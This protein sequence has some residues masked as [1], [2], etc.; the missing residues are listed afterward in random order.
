MYK[1]IKIDIGMKLPVLQDKEYVVK[2][3]QS[4]SLEPYKLFEALN[5]VRVFAPQRRKVFTIKLALLGKMEKPNSWAEWLKS[6]KED[7]VLDE[8]SKERSRKLFGERMPLMPKIISQDSEV[9]RG[10]GAENSD[11]NAINPNG[12]CSDLLSLTMTPIRSEKNA[13]IERGSCLSIP[14]NR[15]QDSREGNPGCRPHGI[16]A[17]RV[18]L[19]IG[20]NF[21]DA[22]GS[23]LRIEKVR[24][25]KPL[26]GNN[27]A[28]VKV[29][30]A[31][32]LQTKPR[33]KKRK[34]NPILDVEKHNGDP[35][36]RPY[37]S[38]PI[39]S[40]CLSSVTS[41]EDGTDERPLT[42]KVKRHKRLRRP[43]KW[44]MFN[45]EIPTSDAQ[46]S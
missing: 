23:I 7:Y 38:D 5:F 46:K 42:V 26:L 40:D 9:N 41:A 16:A 15:M 28:R 32:V 1:K 29:G 2:W 45:L 4:K 34:K 36:S 30:K 25:C 33:K 21:T 22:R 3:N 20:E 10:E 19:K 43:S 31:V 17:D 24:R 14:K 27:D 18:E 39:H 12:P 6:T 44:D 11:R 13:L 8:E 37:V 35:K